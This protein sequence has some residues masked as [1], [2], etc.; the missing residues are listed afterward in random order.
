MKKN[1]LFVIVQQGVLVCIMTYLFCIKNITF[2]YGMKMNVINVYRFGGPC[3]IVTGVVTIFFTVYNI[4]QG[5]IDTTIYRKMR[6]Y[7]IGLLVLNS[8][9]VFDF[10][11]L[12]KLVLVES[13]GLV[14]V[15]ILFIVSIVLLIVGE[16]RI[17][18]RRR[19]YMKQASIGQ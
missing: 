13:I 10:L 14:I 3:M 18:Q 11:V 15:E 5:F 8:F 17:K 6:N 19:E 2:L 1:E 16:S 9:L 7:N 12:K 4:K